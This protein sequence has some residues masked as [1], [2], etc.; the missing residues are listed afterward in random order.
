MGDADDNRPLV[1]A[2]VI[3]A[4][5]GRHPF[6]R[7][8]E[9]P[10]A[11][12]LVERAAT[13]GDPDRFFEPKEKSVADW[14]RDQGGH[15]IVSVDVS[16]TPR[17]RTPDALYRQSD[18]WHT[19]EIKTLDEPTLTAVSRNLR[20]GRHQSTVLVI[21]GSRVGLT[22]EAAEPGLR[23]AVRKYGL[24]FRQIVIRLVDGSAICWLP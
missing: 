16:Q 20:I 1:A 5:P 4:L 19:L 7:P 6:S 24:D 9:P 11:S 23:E 15:T 12:E 2:H 18:N 13:S 10:A 3:P 17:N 21:D 22:G 8:A 14:L